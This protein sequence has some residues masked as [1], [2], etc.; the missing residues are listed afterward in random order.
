MCENTERLILVVSGNK[1]EKTSQLYTNIAGRKNVIA[2]IN[3]RKLCENI[4]KK[5]DQT[6]IGIQNELVK[7]GNFLRYGI[8]S[9]YCE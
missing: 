2:E 4:S 1:E 7:K 8:K 6:V 3:K 5:I 9:I